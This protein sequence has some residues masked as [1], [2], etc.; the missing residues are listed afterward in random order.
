MP[1]NLRNFSV[2]LLIG[3]V[4]GCASTPVTKSDITP[5]VAI[6][7]EQ[8]QIPKES[9]A[10]RDPSQPLSLIHRDKD[11]E[12][13][14][15]KAEIEPGTGAFINEQAAN[16]DLP[17]PAA[18]GQITFNFDNQPIQAVVQAILGELLKENYTIAPGVTGNV[19]FS[20]SKPIRPD[21]ALSILELL[22]S[23]THNALVYKDGRYLI[24]T[25]AEAIPGNLT[26]RVAPPKIP[27]GYEVRVFPLHFISPVEMAKLLKPYARAEAVVSIDTSR[28]M[29]ILAGNAA[30]LENYQR[31][32]EIFD[33]DWLKGMSVG[34]YTLEHI[35]VAKLMPEMEKL[36]GAT[37]ES[38]MAGMFRF[39]PLDRMNAIA[40]ITPNKDY[41]D[42][43][44]KWLHRLDTGTSENTTQ[45]YVYDVKN[46]KAAD[47]S[48]KLN[49][50]FT[51][52]KAAPRR[53]G[54]NVAPGLNP[55]EVRSTTDVS[56]KPQPPKAAPTQPA[57]PSTPVTPGTEN[58]DIRITSIEENNQ[59]LVLATSSEWDTILSA[60]KRLDTPPL[61]VQIET[62]ILEVTLSGALSFGV[63]WYLNGLINSSH[64]PSVGYD[65]PYERHRTALGIGAPAQSSSS[66]FFYSFLNH[67]YE[68]AIN[69]LESNGNSKLL[70]APSL[71]VLNNRQAKINVGQKIPI[72]QNYISNNVLPVTTTTSSGSTTTTPTTS[73]V[74]L[75]GSVQYL[76]TGTILTATPRVNPGGLVFLDVS[77]EVSVAAPTTS[78]SGNPPVNNRTIDTTIAVQSGE[79]VL[80]GGLIREDDS[81]S[82][83]GIPG[84]NHV[85]ILGRLFGNKNDKK[86]RTELI[87]L[88][89]PT[90]ITSS[91]DAREVT[92]EYQRRFQSLKPLQNSKQAAKPVQNS[93]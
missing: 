3:I 33:V 93:K 37:G 23:W 85:P 48:D 5:A 15:V 39:I 84:L 92:E 80:L 58:T 77:Q 79:T 20:T 61:Q 62:R 50:I 29:L 47:L 12:H 57:T 17:E 63:Q 32:I 16:K 76:D 27:R 41:L 9:A 78:V 66:A 6:S 56:K 81:S 90:V 68:M 44:E 69:A 7:A 36:F 75:T 2:A 11:G 22:L 67:D 70:S 52:A 25:V 38:P 72:V 73:G 30:E 8:Q 74:G 60:V 1:L 91:D 46:V 24:T 82:N 21:Q 89:T 87:V 71:V 51:G 86:S 54:G 19:T 59:I 31:T 10:A 4:A 53:S 18:E 14:A 43:A 26:P 55:V 13:P 88:I 45:L 40:V 83:D 49:E 42:Q 65:R 35:E 28:S 34:V 64:S